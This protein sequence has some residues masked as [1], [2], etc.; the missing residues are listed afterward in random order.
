MNVRSWSLGFMVALVSLSIM[1]GP[2]FGE[3][4]GNRGG[5]VLG[6][7]DEALEHAGEKR[8]ELGEKFEENRE[9]L[10]EKQPPGKALGH[11]KDK[12]GKG[13]FKSQKGKGGMEMEREQERVRE[14]IHSGPESLTGQ[15]ESGGQKGLAGAA[16]GAGQAGEAVKEAPRVLPGKEATPLLKGVLPGKVEPAPA[17]AVKEAPRVLPGKEATPLLKGVL[18]EKAEPAPA[19]APQKKPGGFLGGFVK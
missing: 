19:E 4:P 8:G 16:A 12:R 9:R 13:H 2:G 10:R 18:P 17:E 11:F 1:A 3:P 15:M 7:S 5:K 6:K 14:R